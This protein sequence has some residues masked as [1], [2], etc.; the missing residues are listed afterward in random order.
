MSSCSEV[1]NM[2]VTMNYYEFVKLMFEDLTKYIKYYKNI[3]SEYLKKLQQMQEKYY[4]KLFELENE[5]Q[6]NFN[7]IKTNH[8]LSLTCKI[9]K[10]IGQQITNLNFFIN[11]IEETLKSFDKTIKEKNTMAIKYQTEYEDSRN[12]LFKKYKEIEKLKIS[13]L[14]NISLTENIIYRYYLGSIDKNYIDQMESNIKNTKKIENENINS[15]KIVKPFETQFLEFSHNSND[16]IKRLSCEI[17]TKM[18]DSIVDF[19]L[20]LKNCFKLPLSEID[21]YLPE[22]INLDEN[23]KIEEI[24]N[25]TYK[26]VK[27]LN[28]ILAEKYSLKLILTKIKN[29]Q[30]DEKNIIVEEKEILNTYIKMINNFQLINKDILEKQNNDEKIL[31][32]D[33]TLKLLSFSPKVFGRNKNKLDPITQK[34]TEELLKILNKHGNRVIFLETLSNFRSL[35]EFLIPEREYYILGNLMNKILDCVLKD[36]DFYAAKNVIILSQTYFIMKNTDKIYLQNIIKNNKIFKSQNF[37]E[38]LINIS[39]VKEIQKTVNIDTKNDIKIDEKKKNIEMEKYERIIFGQLLPFINNMIEFN[40]DSKIIDNILQTL[41]A[42]YKLKKESIEV[43]NNIIASKGIQ[44]YMK[45]NKKKEEYES[46][47]RLSCIKEEEEDNITELNE[48]I[49]RISYSVFPLAEDEN[50]NNINNKMIKHLNTED[51]KDSNFKEDKN[52]NNSINSEEEEER[53]KQMDNDEVNKQMIKN[54]DDDDFDEDLK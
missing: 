20:L 35:G 3:T 25:S 33:L 51:D 24:I 6:N 7:D 52:I 1:E 42:Y 48:N 26:N 34:E 49:K 38:E 40:V 29:A 14:S 22:L 18:K 47:N 5:N 4:P 9:P 30:D 53:Q 17:S 37:W 32:K 28:P 27:S 36:N 16:N 8:I 31:C 41:I 13:Y 54:I 15:I 39:L 46:K 12:N 50:D 10:I 2:I 21:T 43:I 45:K 19:L 11:G 44:N 23:R